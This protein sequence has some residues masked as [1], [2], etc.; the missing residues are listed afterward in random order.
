MF[1]SSLTELNASNVSG[2]A[3]MSLDTD[4]QMLELDLNL[5]NL[6]PNQDHVFHI[7]GTFDGSDN[8]T[9]ATTPTLAN[10][11]DGDGFI[12]L[13]EGAET[14]GP[15]IVPLGVLNTATGMVVFN[16]TYNLG[17]S[18]T[19][20]AG[21]DAS[22]LMPLNFREIVIH[23]RTVADGPGQGT[24]GEVDGTGGYK[25]V[26][27]VAA[28]EIVGVIPEPSSFVLAGS[29]LVGLLLGAWGRRGRTR[30]WSAPTPSA[31]PA[32]NAPC[33]ERHTNLTQLLISRARRRLSR[34]LNKG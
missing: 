29:A 28:G 32:R 9:D 25:A 5:F 23:G 16:E 17:D 13:A 31:L 30:G 14:Y 21:F 27:P 15:V 4:T 12:E 24:D 34:A 18:N 20:A 26:L 10:D 33:R 22:D 7:H 3:V 6:E 11:T 1:T 2:N 8:P 19:F